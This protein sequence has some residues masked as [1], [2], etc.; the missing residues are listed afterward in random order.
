MRLAVDPR[1]GTI[2][3]TLPGRAALA[4]ALAWAEAQRTWIEAALARTPSE[5][6]FVDGAV[7]PFRGGEL[8]ITH[9]GGPRVVRHEDDRLMVGGPAEAV[10]GCVSRWLRTEALRVLEAETRRVAEK[11]GVTVERVRV[12]DP[13]SRWGSCS[14]SGAIGYS[15]RLILAPPEVLEATVAHEVAHRLH[16]NHGPDFH[17]TVATLLGREPRAERAWLRAHGAGLY[18]IGREG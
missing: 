17:R 4:P 15:W 5:R 12:S 18:A 13:R 14:S 7:L 8:R 3:L 1:D 16:M 10:A 11:A 6:P 2:R 9:V